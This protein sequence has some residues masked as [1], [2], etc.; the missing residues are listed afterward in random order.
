MNIIIFLKIFGLEI[1]KKRKT[2]AKHHHLG[3]REF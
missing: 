2:F 3:W 1:D